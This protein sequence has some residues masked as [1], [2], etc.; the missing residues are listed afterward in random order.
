MSCAKNSKN[1]FYLII[2]KQFA[3]SPLHAHAHTAYKF[4][5]S[6]VRPNQLYVARHHWSGIIFLLLLQLI[7]FFRLTFTRIDPNHN[8]FELSSEFRF[9]SHDRRLNLSR[10]FG[11]QNAKF[12][13][14]YF[15]SVQ[16]HRTGFVTEQQPMNRWVRLGTAKFHNTTLRK[17]R[18]LYSQYYRSLR[19]FRGF[20]WRNRTIE[21]KY[22]K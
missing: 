19:R 13:N 12:R 9:L 1:G 6:R 14:F 22:K 20:R 5:W 17:T 7:L 18:R 21:G 3:F 10:S 2:L 11:T 4:R 15:V 8:G 16:N